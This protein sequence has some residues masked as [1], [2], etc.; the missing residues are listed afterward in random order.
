M[1]TYEEEL[2]KAMD[3]FRKH[4]SSETKEYM[5]QFWDTQKL[6]IENFLSSL[7]HRFFEFGLERAKEIAKNVK[8]ITPTVE[9][10][11]NRLSQNQIFAGGEVNMNLRIGEAIDSELQKLQEEKP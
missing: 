5:G 11:P 10:P 2:K 9:P 8:V 3:K 1:S 7:A 4:Y 6:E